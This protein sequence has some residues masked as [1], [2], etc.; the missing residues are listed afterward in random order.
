VHIPSGFAY[1]ALGGDDPGGVMRADEYTALDGTGLAALVAKGEVTRGEVL[2]AALTRLAEW[3]PVINA[4]VVRSEDQARATTA[5]GPFAGVPTLIKDLGCD[6]AGLPTRNGS[7]LFRDA[8]PAA[9]DS[10]VTARLRAAG[11]GVLGKSGT[12]EFGFG[13][14]TEPGATGAVR[15]PWNPDYSAGGS[16]G[17]SAAAVAAGIVPFAHATDGGGSIRIPA[18]CCNLFGLKPSRG[19]VGMGSKGEGWAGLSVG[20]VVTRSV[21]DSAALLDILGAPAPGEP[22]TAPAPRRPFREEVGADPGRL[23]IGLLVDAPDPA[24]EVDPACRA[25][26]QDAAAR[27]ISLGHEVEPLTW[28]AGLIRPGEIVSV[29]SAVHTA[30]AVDERLAELG[31]EQRDDDLDGATA[32]VV[33]HGRTIALGRYLDAIDNMHATGRLIADF[34]TGYDALL[35]PSMAV[36]PPPIGELDPNREPAAALQG[37]RG[38]AA[39]TSLCNVTGQPAASVPFGRTAEGVPLAVQLIAAYGDE[40]TVFRLAG[41]LL[42]GDLLPTV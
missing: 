2:D 31:R 1:G 10:T 21:R 17:G 19:R 34:M 28:P 39:F 36:P 35:T 29:V 15:N 30:R 40:A 37:M 6:V 11:V 3:E 8:E 24:V 38:M 22:Y 32:I 41:H 18:S 33:G 14:S 4:V 25:L 12:P 20:N 16:S 27:L 9:A 5:P 42:D 26:A 13:T 7:R 23:R